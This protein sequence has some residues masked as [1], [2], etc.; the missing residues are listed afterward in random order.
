MAEAGIDMSKYNHN[1]GSAASTATSYKGVHIDDILKQ[2]NWSNLKSFKRFYFKN[3]E[4][5]NEQ[6]ETIKKYQQVIN[7]HLNPSKICKGNSVT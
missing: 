7:K 6:I 3:I 1:C 5:L 4:S 2:E